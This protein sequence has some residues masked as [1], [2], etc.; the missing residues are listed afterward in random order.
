M[1]GNSFCQKV[2]FSGE[3]TLIFLCSKEQLNL[4]FQNQSKQIFIDGCHKV[5]KDFRQLVSVFGYSETKKAAFAIFHCLLNS[6]SEEH[7][8]LMFEEFKIIL[9]SNFPSF[10][11]EPEI[12]TTKRKKN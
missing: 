8:N 1:K 5:P 7:Y 9:K 3:A 6:K 4:L 12:C 2:I 11:F 10:N